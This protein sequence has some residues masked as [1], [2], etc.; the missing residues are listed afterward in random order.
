MIEP[1]SGMIGGV[2]VGDITR[3]VAN[4]MNNTNEEVEQYLERGDFE[5]AIKASNRD[6]IDNIFNTLQRIYDED[7]NLETDYDIEA[8]RIRTQEYMQ[9]QQA[10]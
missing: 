7:N 10:A 3:R 2:I 9:N 4:R 5:S 1:I 8:S 6:T